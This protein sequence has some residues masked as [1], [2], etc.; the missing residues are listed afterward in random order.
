[1]KDWPPELL[2][3]YCELF[4]MVEEQGAWP[5]ALQVNLVAM[6]D[7]GGSQDPLDKRPIV[8]LPVVYR[9]WAAIRAR[10]FR[11]WLA[12]VGAY[13]KGAG[14]AADAQAYELS[15]GRIRLEQVL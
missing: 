9:L 4:R 5:K 11:A 12:D 1:M 10:T 2:E 14:R 13:P 3:L 8:L 15:R 6:L 7:K